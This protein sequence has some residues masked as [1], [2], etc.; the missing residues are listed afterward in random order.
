MSISLEVGDWKL[1]GMGRRIHFQAV[2]IP[3]DWQVG[4]QTNA[5]TT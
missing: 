2:Y 1:D 5:H 3:Y 4:G